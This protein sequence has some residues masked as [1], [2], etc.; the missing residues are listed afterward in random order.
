MPLIP[1]ARPGRRAARPLVAAALG[2]SLTALLTACGPGEG[3][4]GSG[5]A[6]PGTAA[7]GTSAPDTSAPGQA[8]GKVSAELVGEWQD[9]SDY[10]TLGRRNLD[11]YDPQS[12]W[13]ADLDDVRAGSGIRITADGHYVWSGYTATNISGS[14]CHSRVMSYQRGTATQDGQ[15]IV[16][17][18]EVNRRAYRGGCN[19]SSDMDKEE[20]HSP[21]RWGWQ[22]VADAQGT[23]HLKLV[24]V[25]QS[26]DYVLVAQ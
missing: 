20:S 25:E 6:T 24:S 26:H 4:D 13:P 18:P 8:S 22:R 3:T 10:L 12:G 9:P 14:A 2:L 19:S 23:A 21:Q 16:L 11:I 7:P 5:P 1:T 17:E 15:T